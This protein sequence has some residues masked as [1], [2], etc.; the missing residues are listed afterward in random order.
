MALSPKMFLHNIGGRF[1]RH[2]ATNVPAKLKHPIF[3]VAG[4]VD[5]PTTPGLEDYITDFAGGFSGAWFFSGDVY[6]AQIG[7]SPLTKA[8]ILE[9]PLTRE[10]SFSNPPSEILELM[11]AKSMSISMTFDGMSVT[12][13]VNRGYSHLGFEDDDPPEPLPT[14][15]PEA[16]RFFEPG[17]ADV[18]DYIHATGDI[19]Y[20]ATLHNSIQAVVNG[21]VRFYS[22]FNPT[23][24]REQKKSVD[25]SI[26]P[27]ILVPTGVE[28][29]PE[30]GEYS[31]TFYEYVDWSLSTL[32]FTWHPQALHLSKHDVWV[33]PLSVLA[34]KNTTS[35]VAVLEDDLYA[36]MM[37]Y[38]GATIQ[39]IQDSYEESFYSAH[40]DVTEATVPMGIDKYQFS[41]Q[42]AEDHDPSISFS[43]DDIVFMSDFLPV[44]VT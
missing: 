30:A 44:E 34:V 10:G 13:V 25:G 2:G 12:E 6:S 4:G 8:Q 38:D 24:V 16:T 19:S 29:S 36:I 17:S 14:V 32:R 40:P 20:W 15:D 43:Y 28:I 11:C 22:P 21:G 3:G 33:L 7:A 41:P 18:D 31:L 37:F 39:P 9:D 1:G 27:P 42:V 5:R 23:T 35:S 26:S